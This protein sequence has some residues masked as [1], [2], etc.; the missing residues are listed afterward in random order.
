MQM[1]VN[2]MDR[3]M[4]RVNSGFFAL[5]AAAVAIAAETPQTDMSAEIVMF[6]VFDGILM[7][8]WPTQ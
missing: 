7:N 2:T 6:K 5:Q 1:A 4:A 8:L 3:P